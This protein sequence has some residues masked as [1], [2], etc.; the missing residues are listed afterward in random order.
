MMKENNIAV[1]IGYVLLYAQC[2]EV[3][4]RK[5]VYTGGWDT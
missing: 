2:S 4:E 3:N 5:K 1:Y